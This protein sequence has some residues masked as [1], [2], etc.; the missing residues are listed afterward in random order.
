[1]T[2]MVLVWEMFSASCSIMSSSEHSLQ[3]HFLRCITRSTIDTGARTT[4]NSRR[5]AHTNDEQ[6]STHPQQQTIKSGKVQ[7]ELC[8]SP[9]RDGIKATNT[10]RKYTTIQT[11]D[12]RHVKAQ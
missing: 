10:G 9:C 2:L 5:K 3:P 12:S 4:F 6:A 8:R 7:N 11:R 1:M